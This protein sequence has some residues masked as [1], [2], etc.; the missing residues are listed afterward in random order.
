[1]PLHI[2]L[3]RVLCILAG[4]EHSMLH[5]V[6]GIP[7]WDPD[8]GG[9]A[10]VYMR[11]ADHIAARIAAGDLPAEARLP[12]ERDLAAEYAVAIGTARR[13][14][15]ELRDRGLVVTLPGKG[16]YVVRPPKGMSE[17]R[18]LRPTVGV[19][20]YGSPTGSIRASSRE[21]SSRAPVCLP[22]AS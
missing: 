6:A 17:A 22:N 13:A 12:A 2:A 7:Q 20:T 9:P 10:Y 15:L 21:N 8:A 19:L 14:V 18:S 11:V 3:C 1:M 5:W 4:Q 16:T